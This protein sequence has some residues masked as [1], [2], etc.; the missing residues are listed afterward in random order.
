MRRKIPKAAI[1]ETLKPEAAAEP[2]NKYEA[3]RDGT[4]HMSK[5]IFADR[6]FD[7]AAH[8][9]SVELKGERVALG[10]FE[11]RYIVVKAETGKEYAFAARIKPRLTIESC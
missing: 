1:V 3:W 4:Q 11:E 8:F 5:T 10:S 9:A 6:P 7:A 2:L